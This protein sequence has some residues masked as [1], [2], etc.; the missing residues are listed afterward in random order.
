M[1]SVSDF[2]ARATPLLAELAELNARHNLADIS[3]ADHIGYKCASRAEF[4]S[5]RT[6]L[7]RES[8]FIYQS[9]ISDRPIAIIRLKQPLETALGSVTY[10][11][12]SDQKPDNSQISGFDHLELA[13]RDISYTEL[14]ATALKSGAEFTKKVRPHHTT[15][16]L[17]LS[18]GTIRLEPEPLMV[19]IQRDEIQIGIP[20]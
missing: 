16:D 19:K 10:L 1:L 9:I 11:E 13:P 12:L 17:K 7:E 8:N 6:M 2:F 15:Y 18:S 14:V 4:E 20:R 5:I 3:F